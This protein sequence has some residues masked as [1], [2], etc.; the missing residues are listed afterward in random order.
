[1][2]RLVIA[3]TTLLSLTA[4]TVLG[5]YLFVFAAQADRAARA[6][7]AHTAVYATLYLQPSTGQKLN[8]GELMSHVPGFADTAS[9]DQK[10]HEITARFLGDAGID[11]EADVRPWL[12]DQV[13]LSVQPEGV[14]PEQANMLAVIDVKDP[15]AAETA[16]ARIASDLGLSIASETHEGV[17]V[18]VTA[19]TSWALLDDVVL[20]GSST[21]AVRDGLD[22]DAGRTDSL[23][24]SAAFRDA[25]DDVAADHLASMYVDLEAFGASA[26]LGEQFGGYRTASLAL[27]V[28]PTGLRLEGSAPFDADAASAQANEAFA[29]S[30]EPSSLAEWMPAS[31]Q[32]ELVVFGLSQSLQ[33]A[34]DE[35]GSAEGG[36]DLVGLLTQLR[37][38][39]A[40]GLGINLD[41]DVLPLFDREAAVAISG[42]EGMLPTGQL[43]LRPSDPDAA[44]AAL[45]RMRAALEER[46]AAATTEQV[47]AATVTSVAV[48]ELGMVSY[49]VSEG[50]VV[51]GL[52]AVDVAA[53]LEARGDGRSLAADSRYTQAW[54]LAG[55]RGGNELWLDVG[56]LVDGAGEELGVTGEARDILLQAGALAMTAPARPDEARSDFH[57]VLTVR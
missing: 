49:A 54:E 41:G 45:E 20:V 55:S 12:G 10:I 50:V 52:S 33:A 44:A 31:T 2:H 51:I 18:S 3:L 1:V 56:A 28:E 7:P 34:E 48:P 4:A 43:L 27:L 5:A 26:G 39:A 11:Y 37:A 17:T 24:D 9:L 25:M 32:A 47:G 36:E 13:A 46:G 53:A 16:L 40:L 42:L 30:S 8:L 22:A 19:E 35:L 29:L 15:V 14:D 6:V 38:I 23:A 21:D 57:V